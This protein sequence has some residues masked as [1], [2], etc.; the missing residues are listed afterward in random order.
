ADPANYALILIGRVRPGVSQA[1]AEAQLT[2]AAGMKDYGI[3]V[4]PLSR[5]SVSDQ[6]DTDAGLGTPAVMLLAMSG[7]VLLIA[8][9]NVANMVLARGAAR[10]KEIAVRLAIGGGRGRIVR[11]LFAEGLIL[12]LMGGAGGLLLASWS[13]SALI[14]SMARL[15][16][17]D[18]I[19]SAA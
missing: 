6:P 16:P 7:V 9:L 12:A 15:A 19:Y 11:Q 4:R 8:S 18:I 14:A 2:S 13:T 10:R 3:L 17:L 1:S 5:M